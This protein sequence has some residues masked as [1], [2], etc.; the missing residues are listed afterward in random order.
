VGEN[1]WGKDKNDVLVWQGQKK[2]NMFVL[3]ICVIR[4]FAKHLQV[5]EIAG[6]SFILMGVAFFFRVFRVI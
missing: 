2:K 6:I 3:K 1:S 5:A 4:W